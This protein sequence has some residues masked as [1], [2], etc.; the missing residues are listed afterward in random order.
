[1]SRKQRPGL[2]LGAS[3]AAALVS[4]FAAAPTAHAAG[5]DYVQRSGTQLVLQGAPWHPIGWNNYRLTNNTGG[6]IC[7]PLRGV[8]TDAQMQALFTQFRNNSGANVVR[9]WFFQSYYQANPAQPWAAF[10]RVLS[11]ASAVGLKVIPVLTNNYASCESQLSSQ[12]TVAWYSGGYATAS[13]ASDGYA[14][15]FLDYAKTVAQHYASNTT[16]ALWQLVNEIDP[17]GCTP[18]SE[19]MVASAIHDFG[20]T[21]ATAVKSVDPNHLVGLG[22]QGSGQCGTSGVYYAQVHGA[23][24]IDLCEYHDYHE[25]THAMATGDPASSTDTGNGLQTRLDQCQALGLPLVIGESGILANVQPDGSASGSVTSTTLQQ[26]ASDY[27]AKLHAA[28]AAGV[29]GYLIWEGI[30]DTSDS[31]ANVNDGAYGVGP[32][33]PTLAALLTASRAEGTA[34]SDLPETPS[35]PLVAV[36]GGSALLAASARARR[37]RQHPQAWRLCQARLTH[38]AHS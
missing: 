36:V 11:N 2:W 8:L 9:T 34:P 18:S 17:A 10:D 28:F 1:M 12:K 4:M 37:R 14:L 7:D 29:D 5:S 15:S 21:V 26:R 30:P 27:A 13:P 6:F 31:S 25:A 33:D 23:T 32:G 24:A 19:S 38:S 20:K 35:V 3:A 22:T 16:V